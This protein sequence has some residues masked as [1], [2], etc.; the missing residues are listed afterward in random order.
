MGIMVF[1]TSM[2]GSKPPSDQGLGKIREILPEPFEWCRV[3]SVHGWKMIDDE[4]NSV[5]TFDI[6]AFYMAKYPTTNSFRCSL[7]NQMVL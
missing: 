3:D 6:S 5:G 4:Q 2:K 1:V 7:T